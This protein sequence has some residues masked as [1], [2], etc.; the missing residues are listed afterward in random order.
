MDHLK[1]YGRFL[2]PELRDELGVPL[3][4]KSIPSGS[5][6]STEQFDHHVVLGAL[7]FNWMYQEKRGEGFV[8]LHR[9]FVKAGD[10]LR[11]GVKL[12]DTNSV[13][14]VRGAQIIREPL[15]LFERTAELFLES[16]Y[17]SY[18]HFMD[19]IDSG[20]L[21]QYH[22]FVQF[23][24]IEDTITKAMAKLEEELPTVPAEEIDVPA[25]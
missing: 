3:C 21:S 6:I 23:L 13:L 17:E 16:M 9:A 5:Q 10:Q 15:G 22:R 24:Y 11:T 14:V 8:D 25:N 19:Y 1:I 7:I 2:T 18:H 12:D 20:K 4:A